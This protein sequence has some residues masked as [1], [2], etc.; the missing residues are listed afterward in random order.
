MVF[1]PEIKD[2]LQ[3]CLSKTAEV[4]AI[5]T[6]KLNI[7]EK[8]AE[9]IG[10]SIYSQSLVDQVARNNHLDRIKSGQHDPIEGIAF[11]DALRSISSILSSMQY[12][13]NHLQYRF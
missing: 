8:E 10:Q 9:Q 5:L 7:S 6:S 1:K 2:E 3:I 4:F 12:I 11:L 13:C